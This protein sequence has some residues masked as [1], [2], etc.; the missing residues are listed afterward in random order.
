MTWVWRG[1]WSVTGLIMAALLLIGGYGVLSAIRALPNT[2]AT[3]HL[4]GLTAAVT[5]TRDDRGVPWI[6]AQSAGDAYVALGYVHAQDRFFQMEM[7]RRLGQ[8]RLAELIGRPGLGSDRFMRTL[9]LYRL[10]RTAAA[11]LDPET[12]AAVEAYAKGVNAFLNQPGNA[13][14][15]ELKLLFAAPEPWDIADSLVWQKL[16]GLQLS[17]NWSEELSRAAVI[18]KLGPDRAAELYPDAAAASPVTLAALPA[19]FLSALRLAMDEVVRPTL[20]SNIWAVAG[21][22]TTTGAPLLANDPH[23]NFQSPNLWYLAGLSYPGVRLVGATVPG[24]PFHL[25]GHNGSLAWGFTTTHGDTQD[26]FIETPTPDGRGYVLPDGGTQ[27]FDSREEV[28]AVRFGDA[29]RLIVRASRHGPIVSDILPA[30]ELAGLGTKPVVALS[31]TLLAPEDHSSDAIFAMARAQSV[32]D[33]TNAARRFHAPQQNVMYADRA[34]IGYLAVG[35]IPLR[36]SPACDGM[37]PADGAAGTCDWTGWAAFEQQPQSVDPATGY[38]INA[39]NK[40]VAD[41]YPVLIAKEWHEGYRARRIADVLGATPPFSLQDMRTL[42]QDRISLMARELLPVLLDLLAPAE[43][44]HPLAH[45]LATWDGAMTPERAEPL[46]FALW[47]ERV[48]S[49]LLADDLGD[50]QSELWGA[51]PTLIKS[52]LTARPQWCDDV[53]TD[54]VEDCAGQ[55]TKAWTDAL[56]WLDVNTGTRRAEWTWGRWHVARFDH[57]LFATIPG[58]RALGGF[59]IATGGDDYTVNRGSFAG[60]GAPVPFKHRHGAGYRAVY[61]LAD[62]NR[63]LFSTAGGQSGHLLSGHF[64]DFLEDWAEGR[65]FPLVAP[66]G[67]GSGQLVLTPVP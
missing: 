3:L 19:D 45:Q 52:I 53:T 59:K 14:P 34:S 13:L 66:D 22:R 12:R 61:D 49:A 7:M 27:A 18:A 8:G 16:M 41:D 50:L 15:L 26:L 20:A 58:L 10:A 40:V 9:G 57:P 17:G 67:P 48:K 35:R 28:I 24:V 4:D 25:L 1:V 44:G 23:L 47:M 43:K 37:V 62:L 11:D 21:A 64:D 42:Q 46:I 5:V 55:V 33:F 31:A 39:N 56:G 32:A 60:T 38:L 65:Y 63:S 30:G 36:A 29:E 6:A 2:R 54:A 51:R